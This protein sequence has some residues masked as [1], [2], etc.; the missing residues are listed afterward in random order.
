MHFGIALLT[1]ALTWAA[2]GPP[3]SHVLPVPFRTDAAVDL[4]SVELTIDGTRVKQPASSAHR[5][6]K[7]A[8][9]P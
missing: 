6:L 7:A 5:I 1:G 9:R 2:A 4:K 3:Q 8:A